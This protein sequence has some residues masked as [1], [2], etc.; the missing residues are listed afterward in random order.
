MCESGEHI[1]LW[2]WTV[3]YMCESGEHIKLWY[4]TVMY[5]WESVDISYNIPKRSC[6]IIFLHKPQGSS[7]PG[8]LNVQSETDEW[9]ENNLESDYYIIRSN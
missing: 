9:C 5:M 3:M 6:Q 7:C 4:W 2:D 1:K 8:M